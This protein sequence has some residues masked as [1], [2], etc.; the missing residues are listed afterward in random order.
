MSAPV[1]VWLPATT[2]LLA[3]WRED[4]EVPPRSGYAVTPELRQAWPDGGEEEWE[5]AVLLDAAD[6]AAAMLTAPGRRVVVVVDAATVEPEG[7]SRVRVVQPVP[8]R[9]L[10]AVH[11]DPAGVEVDPG[12]SAED[13]PE[14]CWFAVQEVRGIIGAGDAGGVAERRKG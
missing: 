1:R 8:W 4:R 6:D 3:R 14:L 9:R 11:A 5:Y 2:E 13:A 12:A 10:A 7:G